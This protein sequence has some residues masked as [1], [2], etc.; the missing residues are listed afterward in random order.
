METNFTMLRELAKV[1]RPAEFGIATSSEVALISSTLHIKEMDIL[2]LRNLRD[3][4]VAVFTDIMPGEPRVKLD[5]VSA[6]TA[7]IDERIFSLGGEV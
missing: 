6:I 2:Q 5:A 3:F 4:T 1:Y 7:V